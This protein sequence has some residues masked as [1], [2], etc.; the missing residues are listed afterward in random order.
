MITALYN[1]VNTMG[2]HYS[3][4]VECDLYGD[5]ANYLDASSGTEEPVE[6]LENNGFNTFS[7]GTYAGKSIA[8]LE[9]HLLKRKF[10]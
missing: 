6:E 9:K 2:M 10:G 8:D 1:A 4:R 5:N 7:H 3:Q